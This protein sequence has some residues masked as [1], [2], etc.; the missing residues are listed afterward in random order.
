MEAMEQVHV[1]DIQHP[2]QL[3]SSSQTACLRYKIVAN[4]YSSCDS[5]EPVRMSQM[6]PIDIQR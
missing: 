5:A 3:L 6:S 4:G 2:E 1:W